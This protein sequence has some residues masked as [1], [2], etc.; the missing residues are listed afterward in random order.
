LKGKHTL[1][2]SWKRAILVVVP[3]LALLVGLKFTSTAHAALVVNVSVPTERQVFVPC[4]NGGVGEVI[5][6]SGELH[7]LISVTLDANGGFHEHILFNP[8]GVSGFGL[9][10]GL[11][12]QGVG[13]AEEDINGTVGVTD[14]FVEVFDMIGQG[15]GNN[16]KLHV[17]THITVNADGSLTSSVANI[18]STCK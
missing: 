16:F 11:K 14:T 13:I 3:L 12:Y 15:P 9:T 17:T 7:A 4:A 5:A 10:T 6:I 18:F 2:G 8:Q 1:F